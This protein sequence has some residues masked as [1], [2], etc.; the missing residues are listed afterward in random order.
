MSSPV[1]F[2]DYIRPVCIV[3]NGTRTDAIDPP[4]FAGAICSTLGW[5]FT[6]EY[7]MQKIN[8]TSCLAR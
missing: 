7:N 3:P 4:T 2:T 1:V 8:I 6:C 5:G